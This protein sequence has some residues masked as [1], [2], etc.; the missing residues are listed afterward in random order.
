MNLF[1]W[2]TIVPLVGLCGLELGKFRQDR[3]RVRL[4]RL[5]F[6]IAA[7]ILIYEPV[8]A[9]LAA[10]RLGIG[11]GTDLVFYLFMLVSPAIWFHLYNRQFTIRRDLVELARREALRS[12]TRGIEATPW[13]P[14]ADRETAP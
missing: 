5:T 4:V 1:Q 11:R 6:W 12:P 7:I 14:V 13:S 10:G 2:L 3:R 9:S 8:L